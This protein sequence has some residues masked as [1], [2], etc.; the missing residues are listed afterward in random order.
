MSSRS[1]SMPTKV[2]DAQFIGDLMNLF[3]RRKIPIGDP[4]IEQFS[5]SRRPTTPSRASASPA[6]N[7]A[8]DA[9]SVSRE[10]LGRR[11][12]ETREE[13]AND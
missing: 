2:S 3:E 5:F 4:T 9:A 11:P 13:R 7:A 10:H 6:S 8:E 1:I 12:N